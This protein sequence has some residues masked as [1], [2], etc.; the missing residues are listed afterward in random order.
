MEVATRTLRNFFSTTGTSYRVPS[1]DATILAVEAKAALESDKTLLDVT[2]PIVVVG[3]LHG[4]LID[5]LH[6]L[7]NNGLPPEQKYLFLGDFID[8]GPQ[9]IETLCLLFALKIRFPK[10]IFLLRGNHET[11]EMAENNEFGKECKTRLFP[12]ALVIF[13]EAFDVIPIAAVV[14][15]TIFCIHGG[16]SKGFM[17]LSDIAKIRR[18]LTLPESGPIADLFWSD[19]CHRVQEWGPSI[20]GNTC[21]WGQK[22]AHKFME[23]NGLTMIVRAHQ[24]VYEGYGFPFPYDRSVVTLYSA[25][26]SGKGIKNIAAYMII[27]PDAP[28][29]YVQ[30]A[31]LS[32]SAS[33]PIYWPEMYA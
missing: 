3:D 16:L 15:G 27:T 30:M 32:R 20:R 1:A 7:Q 12:S 24:V 4:H 11:L 31:Q 33:L 17:K 22:I 5:L 6:V 18:P 25:S 10:N 14:D 9:S 19:P 26:T 28:P 8:R 13:A 29:K 21:V 2:S 23:D